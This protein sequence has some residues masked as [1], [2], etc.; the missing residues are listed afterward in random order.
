MSI[1]LSCA[2]LMFHGGMHYRLRGQRYCVQSHSR[3]TEKLLKTQRVDNKSIH[4]F[5]VFQAHS[6]KGWA[7]FTSKV[8]ERVPKEEPA[9]DDFS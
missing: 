2:A 1:R 3:P 7:T 8:R 6:S 9:D 5:L 4:R